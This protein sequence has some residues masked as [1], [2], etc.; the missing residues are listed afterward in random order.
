MRCSARGE[1]EYPEESNMNTNNNDNSNS[2]YEFD[3]DSI[4]LEFGALKEEPESKA[5]VFEP[6]LPIK[7]VSGPEDAV[8]SSA[9]EDGL[10]EN[11][12]DSFGIP[13]REL[14]SALKES[15]DEPSDTASE[16]DFNSE[17]ILQEFESDDPD[18]LESTIDPNAVRAEFE[19]D[20]NLPVAVPVQKKD[21]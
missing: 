8:F 17:N 21:L 7:D 2:M 13:F 14:A 16:F 19:N 18:E 11:D 3:I 4:L 1:A 15:G 12:D 9:I 6:R 20:G 5:P 10:S